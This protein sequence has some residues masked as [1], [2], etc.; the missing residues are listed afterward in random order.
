M[1]WE[2]YLPGHGF[3]TGHS[4]LYKDSN[5]VE[6]VK[7][8]VNDIKSSVSGAR[9]DAQ[10]ALGELNAALSQTGFQVSSDALDGVY[11]WL[12]S[13][14]GTLN[15][16]IEA[17]EKGADEYAKQTSEH[18][19]LT[20]VATFGMVATSVGEGF[21]SAF[22]DVGDGVATITAGW[23]SMATD[24]LGITHGANEKVSAC[25]E[26]DLSHEAF[27]AVREATG[28]NQFSAITE[29]SGLA[30]LAKT[31]GVAG[32]YLTMGGWLSGVGEGLSTVGNGGKFVQGTAKLLSSTTR[33]N[34]VIAA[35]GGYGSGM[36]NELQS[37]KD[38]LG[39]QGGALK[40]SASQAGTAYA[41]GKLGEYGQKKIAIKEA[42]AAA[43]QADDA[44]RVAKETDKISSN[45]KERNE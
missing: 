23:G 8:Q 29:D 27:H 14:L 17:K 20:G 22:E 35:L 18:P 7:G 28:I 21:V 11:E 10:A 42:Q 36:E 13:S 44:A 33:A 9:A 3:W 15:Q 24:A 4:S 6:Y 45:R 1:N 43:D 5:K 39:A 30:G 34:T 41:M 19:F 16:Q 26:R 31:A 32:G 25:I 37:G 12:E 38:F 2:K 40:Q